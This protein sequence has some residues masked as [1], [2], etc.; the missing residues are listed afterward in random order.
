[1]TYLTDISTFALNLT[2]AMGLALAVDYTLLIVSRFRDERADG[3]DNEQALI[4]TM[5]TAGRTVLFSALTVGCSMLA[6]A[7]FPM[8][9]LRSFA[10]AGITVVMLTALAALIIGPAAIMVLGDRIDALDLR[11]LGRR[12]FRRPAAPQQRT[13]GQNFFYRSAA[14]AIRYSLPVIV[15]GT[16]LLLLLGAPFLGIK[17]GFPDERMLPASASARQVGDQLRQDFPNDPTT[18]V[19]VVHPRHD[20]GQHRRAE[21]V[22]RPA[23]RNR[24]RVN[25][26]GARR[27]LPRRDAGRSAIRADRD[28]R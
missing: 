26:I 1:M 9:F 19:T 22:R 23:V 13:T 20:S 7:L 14:F 12:L 27:H 11:P 17:W 10:F 5:A 8:Y 21:Q 3:A 28:R 2:I 6:L 25:G 4:R 18:A 24:L 15:A 16:V